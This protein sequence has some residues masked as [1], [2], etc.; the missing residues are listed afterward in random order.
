[1]PEIGAPGILDQSEKFI[2]Y[3]KK[4]VILNVSY[5]LLLIKSC[6]YSY[7][8]FVN[9]IYLDSKSAPSTGS[10]GMNVLVL[11]GISSITLCALG[12]IIIFLLYVRKRNWN[13]GNLCITL[14]P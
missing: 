13:Q 14:K 4:K 11:V 8:H 5:K 1:M 10:E 3:V 6:L 2:N 7:K 9:V 12:V